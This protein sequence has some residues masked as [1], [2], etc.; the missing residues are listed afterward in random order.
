MN[1]E[2]KTVLQT[3]LQ[4]KDHFQEHF[5]AVVHDGESRTRGGKPRAVQACR[6]KATLVDEDRGPRS[7]T[8]PLAPLDTP[9]SLM[10]S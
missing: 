4:T 1:T 7:P 2:L 5:D 6:V 3:V 10:M 8:C 9:P